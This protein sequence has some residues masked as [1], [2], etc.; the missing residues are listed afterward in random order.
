M[1][2]SKSSGGIAIFVKHE[3]QK[4]V[5]PIRTDN[6]DIIW[7]KLGGKSQDVYL[8]TIYLNPHRGKISE[9]HKIKKLAE[10]VINFK[11]KGGQVIL[12]GDLNARVSNEKDFLEFD[13]FDLE[14]EMDENQ[15]TPRNSEDKVTCGRG[16]ELLE[17]CKSLD[18]CILN[19]R[20]TGD[21]FGKFT[22]FQWKGNGVVDYLICSQSLEPDILSMKVG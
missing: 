17:L 18:L 9:S 2:T 6:E 20:K 8:G 13:K 22:S 21:I 16:N 5:Q 1:K 10:D 7:L 11:R 12:Q 19:G 15:M 4:L 3:L 14:G